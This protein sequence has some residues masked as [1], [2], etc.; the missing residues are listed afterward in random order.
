M[1]KLKQTLTNDQKGMA[2]IIVAVTLMLII[3][4]IVL[5]MSQNTQNE[6]RQALDR[7]LSDQAF[8]NAESGINDVAY[9][10]YSNPNAAVDKTDCNTSLGNISN[11]IDG[12]DGVNKYTCVLYDKAPK[13]LQYD[14]LSIS[15]PKIIPIQTVNDSGATAAL[16][17]LTISWDDADNRD[18]NISGGCNFGSGSPALPTSCDYGGVRVELI[19]PALN[20]DA[21][22][23]RSL[24]AFLLPNNGAVGGDIAVGGLGYPNSQG[25]IQATNC[26]NTDA[27]MRRCSKTI[28]QIGTGN[29]YLSI[30]S[31]YRPI[32]VTITGVDS[33]NN[34]LRF[35][36]TQIVVDS[37]GKANDVLRRVQVRIPAKNQYVYPGFA[38]QSKDSICKVLNVS[39][40]DAGVGNV[41]TANPTDCPIN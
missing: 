13:S 22:R 40:N 16:E 23:E 30:R 36:D 8:Y 21:M 10:L 5:A 19:S 31:L 2:S 33:F 24:I 41:A 4:L 28:T 18:G 17:R 27:A 39:L 6:Q 14:N 9:Y 29:L 15:S 11:Q 7:Q 38:L 26:S 37:T 12:P 1:K 3:S 35:K 32:N 34:A 25:L 20:R